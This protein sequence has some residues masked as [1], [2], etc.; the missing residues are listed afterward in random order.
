MIVS[1]ASAFCASTG[2]NEIVAMLIALYTGIQSMEKYYSL[3]RRLDA[4]NSGVRKLT[5]AWSRWT[6]MEPLQR[7]FNSSLTH[8]VDTVEN[9]RLDLVNA[10]TAGVKQISGEVDGKNR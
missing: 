2:E 4:A 6:S 1:L 9:A 10:S 3:Q 8:L 5:T 7:R